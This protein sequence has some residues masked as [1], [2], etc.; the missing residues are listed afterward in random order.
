MFFLVAHH[1]PVLRYTPDKKLPK[2]E[3]GY[4]RVRMNGLPQHTGVKASSVIQLQ[5]HKAVKKKKTGERIRHVQEHKRNEAVVCVC[6][7]TCPQRAQ[8]RLLRM[9]KDAADPTNRRLT[10]PELRFTQSKGP[11]MLVCVMV[12]TKKPSRSQA[13][14]SET[15]S[16]QTSGWKAL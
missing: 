12:M 7:S 14:L 5:S 4:K 6:E 13:A 16:Q 1:Q 15:A 9:I 3:L 8:I 10:T 2:S 11:L